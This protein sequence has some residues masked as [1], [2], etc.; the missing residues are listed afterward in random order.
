MLKVR[1]WCSLRY[2]WLY[3]CSIQNQRQFSSDCSYC[4]IG[5]LSAYTRIPLS[6][7]LLFYLLIFFFHSF[8]FFGTLLLS[9]TVCVCI[10][11]KRTYFFL[12][13]VV[14]NTANHFF[15]IFPSPTT[16]FKQ[17]QVCGSNN[18]VFLITKCEEVNRVTFSRTTL[19]KE[20]IITCTAIFK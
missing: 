3:S 9:I 5:A 6:T 20:K 16:L 7:F 19:T 10:N 11:R 2:T 8:D 12:Y 14:V 18:V 1:L 13:N 17:I 15:F 4:V